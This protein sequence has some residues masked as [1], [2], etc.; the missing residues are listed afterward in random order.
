MTNLFTHQSSVHSHAGWCPT[1][2]A[3]S[4]PHCFKRSIGKTKHQVWI[5]KLRKLVFLLQVESLRT[6]DDNSVRPSK[7]KMFQCSITMDIFYYKLKLACCHSK[8]GYWKPDLNFI[9]P[10]EFRHRSIYS[11]RLMA[12]RLSWWS[13]Y[14]FIECYVTIL[15]LWVVSVKFSEWWIHKRYIQTSRLSVPWLPPQWNINPVGMS[16]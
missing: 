9:F 14:I 12:V 2:K 1:N 5:M 3:D 11:Y 6:E 8:L 16:W 15:E 10:C 7:T 13:E 4:Y